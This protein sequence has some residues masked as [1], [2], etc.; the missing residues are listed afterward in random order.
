MFNKK[1]VDEKLKIQYDRIWACR[2]FELSHLWQRSIF[3]TAFLVLI[4]TGYGTLWI[5]ALTSNYEDRIIIFHIVS[6]VISMLG[7]IF[8]TLWVF[9]GKGSKYWYEVYEDRI[10][11]LEKNDYTECIKNC[12]EYCDPDC[13]KN[14]SKFH[15]VQGF[16]IFTEEKNCFWGRKA[17]Q[18]SVS[19]IN[20]V[21]G[22]IMTI[23]WSLVLLFHVVYIVN[24][25]I[26]LY[27]ILFNFSCFIMSINKILYL[28]W[29]IA[30]LVLP[31]M[32]VII[33]SHLLKVD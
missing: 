15:Q 29:A 5:N 19:G 26:D 33:I 7:I 2:D 31:L 1:S 25:V 20:I 32:F 6:L 27:M 11:E 12:E 14:C 4:F 22:Q 18:Y 24:V 16:G 8:S 30:V 13:I 28:V 10:S 23:L 21:I 9:M 3:L 17:F